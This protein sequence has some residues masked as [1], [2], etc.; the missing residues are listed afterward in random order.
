MLAILKLSGNTKVGNFNDTLRSDQYVSSFD[1]SVNNLPS[2]KILKSSQ[3]LLDIH[4][5]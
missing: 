2:M 1:I 4:S 3:Y 5:H